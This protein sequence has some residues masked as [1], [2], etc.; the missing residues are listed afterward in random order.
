MGA[1]YAANWRIAGTHVVRV[2]SYAVSFSG[3]SRRC[4]RRLLSSVAKSYPARASR[5][6]DVASC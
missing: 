2:P 1:V 4:V 3:Y 5:F 6:A